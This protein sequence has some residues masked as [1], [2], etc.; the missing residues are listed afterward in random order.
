[1]N[2]PYANVVYCYYY[3]ITIIVIIILFRRCS[4]RR[5]VLMP[6]RAMGPRK[7]VLVY[8]VCDL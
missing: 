3:I 7:R 1:M 4:R 6:L 2:A 8:D 5:L